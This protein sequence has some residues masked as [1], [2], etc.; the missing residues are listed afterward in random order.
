MNK[1]ATLVKTILFLPLC[2]FFTD[3]SAPF[4]I[5]GVIQVRHPRPNLRPNCTQQ[6]FCFDYANL[7]CPENFTPL[8][9]TRVNLAGWE[10]S[11]FCQGWL[12][13]L[14]ETC[15]KGGGYWE[16]VP[17][18][19]RNNTIIEPIVQGGVYMNKGKP[20]LD[21]ITS[22]GDGSRGVLRI[23]FIISSNFSEMFDLHL[24]WTKLDF[25]QS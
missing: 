23:S 14:T 5:T 22:M 1:A 12:P 25:W 10:I 15:S 11:Q 19:P 7:S 3:I 8:S 9:I 6:S 21:I 20:S 24:I 2:H 17:I 4:C 16:L 13:F 18:Y